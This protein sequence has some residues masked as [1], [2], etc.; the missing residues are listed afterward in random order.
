VRSHRQLF[1]PANVMALA[2][3]CISVSFSSLP[4]AM[5]D[6]AA[7]AAKATGLVKRAKT[8]D[9]AK[10][11]GGLKP[12]KASNKAVGSKKAAN[13]LLALD[14]TGKIP[15]RALPVLRGPGGT[16]AY[17]VPGPKGEPGPTGVRGAAGPAGPQGTQGLQ[18]LLGPQGPVG[19]IASV[20]VRTAQSG[21][22]GL[23]GSTEAATATC[24]A[25]EKLIGGSGY[26]GSGLLSPVTNLLGLTGNVLGFVSTTLGVPVDQATVNA[27]AYTVRGAVDSSSRVVAQAF[28]ATS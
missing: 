24:N 11:L 9:N 23:L 28:C 12:I 1:Q 5:A 3:L 20:V 25:G 2:A 18:G 22:G 4:A 8:A 27:T 13:R 26:V 17:G 21:L 15:A 10:K 16:V 6:T 19:S 14:K 7:N